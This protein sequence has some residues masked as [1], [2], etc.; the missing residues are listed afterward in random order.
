VALAENTLRANVDRSDQQ[1]LARQF[2]DSLAA[3]QVNAD[4]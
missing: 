1:E 4:A 2:L 3:S